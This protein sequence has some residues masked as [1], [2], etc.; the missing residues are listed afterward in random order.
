MIGKPPSKNDP[1]PLPN[2]ISYQCFPR[3][4]AEKVHQNDRGVPGANPA[5]EINED[6]GRW[7]L[8]VLVLNSFGRLLCTLEIENHQVIHFYQKECGY[9]SQKTVSEQ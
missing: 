3:Q 7:S 4:L 1:N 9:H 8:R 2:I 5:C 6:F